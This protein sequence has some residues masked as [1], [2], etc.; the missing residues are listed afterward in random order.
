MDRGDAEQLPTRGTGECLADYKC[1]P[2]DFELA[3]W[4]LN[5]LGHASNARIQIQVIRIVFFDF[6][7]KDTS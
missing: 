7:I 6:R 1:G 4:A 2:V 5:R 3:V